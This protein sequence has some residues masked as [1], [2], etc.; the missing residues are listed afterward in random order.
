MSKSFTTSEV[1][2][3]DRDGNAWIIIDGDVYDVSK[4]AQE[5]P[6]GK[7]ILLKYAGKD[8]SKEFRQFHNVDL[9]IN[10]YGAKLRVGK[11]A[12]ALGEVKKASAPAAA[13]SGKVLTGENSVFGDLAPFCEP[14]WYQDWYTPYY[15]DS[16]KR[17]RAHMREWCKANSW[18][19]HYAE[20]DALLRQDKA[21]PKWVF[22]AIGQA[23]LFRVI[24]GPPW[25]APD[26][27]GVP[28]LPMGIK[29]KD[30]NMFH[31]LIVLDELG[32][33]GSLA[34]AL[35]GGQAFAIPPIMKYGSEKMK[36]EFVPA[37]YSGK[38]TAAL[39]ITEPHAGSDVQN[40]TTS[41]KLSD[42]G[43]F[44][45]VN[46]EKKWITGGIWAD[47]FTTAVRTGGPGGSGV[48]VMMIPRV[49]GVKTRHIEVSGG[50]MGGTSYVTFEDVKVPVDMIIGEVNKGL[51]VLMTNLN[52]KIL[53][54][55]FEKYAHKRKTFGKFLIE[56]PVIRAKFAEMARNV[57]ASQAW[58]EQLCYQMVRTPRELQDMRLGGPI[59]LCKLQCSRTLELCAREASQILGG[60]AYTKGGVGGKVEAI[61]RSNRGTAIP[62]GSE[63]IMADL[64][65]KRDMSAATIP[66]KTM[67][68]SFT[69]AEVA[70]HDRE[71]NAWIIIDGEVFDVSK[72]AA[73]HPG[74]KKILLKVAGKDASKEFKQF[75][76]VE[77]V[78]NTYGSKLK[79]GKVASALG[80]VKK[81]APGA[82]AVA[83]KV[84]TGDNSV[85]GDL[86][87]FCEPS[88]YQDWYSPYYDESHRKL[89]AHMREWCQK[90][91][92]VE[93]YSEWEALLKQDKP[94]PRWAF[95]EIG[96][97]GLFRVIVGPPW[98]A[99]DMPGVPDLPMGI[100]SKDWNMFHE[101]IVLDE[102]SAS[103]TLANALFGGQAFAI[104][105]IMKYGSEKMKRE[106]VPALYAGKITVA[107]AI[108]EPQA[109]SDVQNITTTAKLSDDGKFWIVN[110]EKKWITG[111]IWAEWFTTAVRTGGPGGSGV[112]IMMIPRTQ[113]VKTRHIEVSGGVM[114]GTSYVTFEDV[115]VPVDMIIGEVNK[116]LR[117]LMTN[118]NH[119]R[120]LICIGAV[121][122]ARVCLQEA[123]HYAHKRKTFGKFL[124]EVDTD[125]YPYGHFNYNTKIALF[126]HKHPV[127]RAKF[128]EMAR[129][130]EA[131]QA[132]V[133]QLCHQM[134]LT[135][136]ELQDMRLGGP[137]ALCKLQCS[138][139]VELCAREASQILGGIA[140]TK[141]GVG[142]KVESIYRGNRGTAIPGGS[143]E[144]MADLGVR[145][146][147]KWANAMGA[148]LGNLNLHL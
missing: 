124:I 73:E 45:I 112:S 92:W 55:T 53:F 42:D 128:A 47:W 88:W 58:I 21:P 79:I 119:E 141:G 147:L 134:V 77:L 63:E 23:G 62:G 100:K 26:M 51:R 146:H 113:G 129:N 64:E 61:Y 75:H 84:L 83:S 135:P 107:L 123:L 87:P 32:A 133:E 17:L 97:A 59:A 74:G 3:H 52:V 81:A 16:H 29:S 78:L 34:R 40:I 28:D 102:M 120:I 90:N 108:T 27:P 25:Q 72:F 8:A 121:R 82:S 86:A 85:F 39:A 106:F 7:K 48:S 67:S 60:I 110:G 31:E 71:G 109:G 99:P 76:N 24:V 111:G 57:E 15:D 118:F 2:Q 18:V 127:I 103:G 56:H 98:A 140:Y 11:V 145:Q 96:K 114:G 9:V 95:E 143:E 35:F 36:R 44:W 70:Q 144:I 138:K 104:P 69:A 1:A 137:I 5:H 126:C 91:S 19:Q 142:G 65:Y 13:V 12:S 80:E 101:L 33:S 10:T 38:T 4:F 148:N 132:W 116:G 122:S 139:T 89:R 68:K 6:G 115:K 105:P 117:A 41:A 94:L 66:R 131:T 125:S 30:W 20:W 54:C 130:I 22:E 136:R 37:L 93:Y 14:A 43:K 46:G 50:V 49:E